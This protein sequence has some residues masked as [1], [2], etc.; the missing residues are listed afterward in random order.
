MSGALKLPSRPAELGGML[1]NGYVGLRAPAA[2]FRAELERAIVDAEANP[3]LNSRPG[4]RD[5]VVSR[6]L[7]ML[8]ACDVVDDRTNAVVG[9]SVAGGRTALTAIRGTR[10]GVDAG[11]LV[12]RRDAGWK[13]AKGKRTTVA[14][15]PRALEAFRWLPVWRRR[16]LLRGDGD[17]DSPETRLAP[18]RRELLADHYRARG[19]ELEAAAVASGVDP[20]A[21]RTA[22][23]VLPPPR[24]SIAAPAAAQ[25]VGAPS[26]VPSSATSPAPAG[27]HAQ[28]AK[29]IKPDTSPTETYRTEKG[30]VLLQVSDPAIGASRA[31]ARARGEVSPSATPLPRASDRASAPPERRG[32]V[33]AA[34]A[35]VE[36][37]GEGGLHLVR[38]DTDGPPDETAEERVRRKVLER[39]AAALE[40]GFWREA[41][42]CDRVLAALR[43]AT[44][45]P[46][47]SS[48]SWVAFLT[49]E[50]RACWRLE[51]EQACG[52]RHAWDASLE[53]ACEHTYQILELWKQVA[54]SRGWRSS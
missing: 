40:R 24:P 44:S 38:H 41:Q 49:P 26:P 42:R 54:A 36:K 39:K 4:V 33:Q 8:A 20:W 9:R 3:K 52:G 21:R 25:E 53:R 2:R 48:P 16:E 18:L 7:Q 27:V 1:P 30:F 31:P 47:P 28:R 11:E 29:Y 10:A 45:P 17:R 32:S 15:S 19:L 6:L 12:V 22:E 43:T 23:A 35:A 46:R 51:R 5:V 37:R 14:T 50:E 34:G 13:P